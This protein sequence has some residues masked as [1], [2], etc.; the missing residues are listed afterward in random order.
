MKNSRNKILIK[1]TTYFR[2]AIFIFISI[3]FIILLAPGYTPAQQISKREIFTRAYIY[4]GFK[5]LDTLRASDNEIDS[6]VQLKDLNIPKISFLPDSPKSIMIYEIK[7]GN[8]DIRKNKDY[9][10]KNGGYIR[11]FSVLLD[12]ETGRFLMV[13]SIEDDS[14]LINGNVET[15]ITGET[16][17]SLIEELIQKH[18]EFPDRFPMTDFHT[19]LIAAHH[20][21]PIGCKLIEGMYII[22]ERA[23]GEQMVAWK[24]YCWEGYPMQPF[25]FSRNVPPNMRDD[26]SC[27]VIDSLG[28]CASQSTESPRAKSVKIKV[29]D[30]PNN[31][32][33]LDSFIDR[34]TVIE[35]ALKYTGFDRCSGFDRRN[36]VASATLH[37]IEEISDLSWTELLNCLPDSVWVVRF[38]DLIISEYDNLIFPDAFN[39]WLD[40]I[41][42]NLIRIVSDTVDLE[43]L[44]FR[45]SV[46]S[47]YRYVNNK[48][49]W[50]DSALNN[51][52]GLVECCPAISLYDI[53]NHISPK[54]N[55]KAYQISAMLVDYSRPLVS[56]G[57]KWIIF[58]TG[59][60][61][62]SGG[63]YDLYSNTLYDAN[64]GKPEYYD[65][66]SVR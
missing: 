52:Y 50:R 13:R 25:G 41:N 57:P 2:E 32:H 31:P 49:L 59:I 47:P 66:K 61:S 39:V 15:E 64:T 7:A 43:S 42:G 26:N 16:E 53:L 55:F 51:F 14:T 34:E 63:G 11:D 36:N 19:A 44:G 46:I 5:A 37:G 3:I 29:Y 1:E 27:I 54:S 4:T 23:N 8:V 62:P 10:P 18:N 20:C 65:V 21:R 30:T 48:E 17:I 40:P 60:P 56:L 6:L 33:D 28:V 9:M 38:E 22:H 12:A 24:I 45:D 35:K 58:K